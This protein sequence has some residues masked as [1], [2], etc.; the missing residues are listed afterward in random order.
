MAP[1]APLFVS[2]D[3]PAYGPDVTKNPQLVLVANALEV[4]PALTH[5]NDSSLA[6]WYKKYNA[7]NEAIA[8]LE[9]LKSANQWS[10]PGI[11][12]TELINLFSGRA[13]WHSHIKKSFKDIQNYRLMV[14]WLERSNEDEEPS[15]LDVWHL[16]K[17]HYT[18]KD[19][20]IWKKEGTLD[21]EYQKR[22]K[23]KGKAKIRTSQRKEKRRMEDSNEPET[24][25][26][27]RSSGSK[28]KASISKSRK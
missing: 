9:Q 25:R 4:N 22:Q 24:S 7:W 2:A 12:R 10:L 20:G 1:A 28:I 3:S 13:F 18:F 26:K 14:D 23:E 17:P 16:E 27:E 8:K 15:N 19:L 5:R 11:G 6:M 21:K